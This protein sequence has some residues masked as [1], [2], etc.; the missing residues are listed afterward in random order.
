MR[1]THLETLSTTGHP[2]IAVQHEKT[3]L[4]KNTAI[5][6]LHAGA[7]RRQARADDAHTSA[8]ESKELVKDAEAMKDLARRLQEDAAGTETSWDLAM[9]WI[10]ARK[11]VL[12]PEHEAWM[13]ARHI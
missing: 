11:A 13:S 12:F 9:T 4:I 2:S 7:S 5:Q 3:P 8:S 1:I 6:F 10:V